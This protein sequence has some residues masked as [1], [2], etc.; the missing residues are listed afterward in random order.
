ME[1]NKA[2]E[3]LIQAVDI[4][5]KKGAYSLQDVATVLEAIKTLQVKEPELVQE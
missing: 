5:V 2:I 4:A 1:Q 3:V